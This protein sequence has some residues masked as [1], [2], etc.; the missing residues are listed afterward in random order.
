[1][2]QGSELKRGADELKILF[3][4][5]QPLDVIGP[6]D[7]IMMLSGSHNISLSMIG[8]EKGLVP[9]PSPPRKNVEPLPY[10][11]QGPQFLATHTFADAPKLDILLAPGGMGLRVLN[12]THD[13]WIPDFI[14]SRFDQLQYL[15]SVCTGAATLAQSGVLKGRRATTNKAAWDWATQFGEGVNWVPTARWTEDGKIWTSSGVSAGI[16]MSYAF[17]K[18]L[19]GAEAVNRVLNAMEYTPHVNQR[20]DPY[21]LVH[22]V[23]GADASQS[24][25]ECV[26]PVG[27]EFRCS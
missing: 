9:A 5:F 22:K 8:K 23:P 11:V 27:Y 24:M 21:S 19:M 10:P 4:G 6:L 16:D 13:T 2:T 25:G 26:G 7:L 17:F 18:K 1:M 3:P 12:D 15:L 14:A 20:W